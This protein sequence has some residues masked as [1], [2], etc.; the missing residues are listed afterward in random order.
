VAELILTDEAQALAD[1]IND[2][3]L[4]GSDHPVPLWPCDVMWSISHP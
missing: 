2:G 4:I 1:R 3:E